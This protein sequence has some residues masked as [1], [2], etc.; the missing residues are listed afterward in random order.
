MTYRS[1]KQFINKNTQKHNEKIFDLMP[2]DIK[3]KIIFVIG[4]GANNTAEMLCSIMSA[5]D[6][7]Y[8]RY[9]ADVTDINRRFLKNGE[10]VSSECLCDN[11]EKIIKRA[12]KLL[13]NDDLLFALAIVMASEEFTVIEMS[14]DFYNQIKGRISPQAIILAIKNDERAFELIENAP[15]NVKE[16]ISLSEKDNFDYISTQANKN[17]ARITLA[18]PNKITISNANLLGV[19]FYHYSYLYHVWTL[20]LNNVELAHLAIESASAIFSA[21]RPYIYKGLDTVTMPHDLILYSLSPTI[22]LCDEDYR[23]KLHHKLK[24]I[25]VTEND[26]FTYPTENT[27]FCGNRQYIEKIK[28]KLKKR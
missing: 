5:C 11:A 23:F 8:T 27:I 4:E 25:I 7:R 10:Y 18:S 14:E 9:N 12:K 15:S 22:L 17:G 20:D 21:P 2:L 26:E 16:I 6:I 19:D 1:L 28:E 24:F 13:S 3:S